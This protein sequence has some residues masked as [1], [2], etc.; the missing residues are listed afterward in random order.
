MRNL[1]LILMCSLSYVTVAQSFTPWE[2]HP[3]FD[4]ETRLSVKADNDCSVIAF[5]IACDI[6][7]HR[8]FFVHKTYFERETPRSVT[9]AEPFWNNVGRALS[10]L[11]LHGEI[12]H[13]PDDAD[14]TVEELVS[15]HMDAFLYI[16]IDH[17]ALASV[18]GTIFN[19]RAEPCLECKVHA[20]FEVYQTP[21]C[22]E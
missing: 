10:S 5:A 12:I 7:Y 18:N 17:H 3:N 19:Q 9:N 13:R 11:H 21:P 16:V 22:G 20:A 8:S 2:H 14:V 6:P 15:Q 1:I 4:Y